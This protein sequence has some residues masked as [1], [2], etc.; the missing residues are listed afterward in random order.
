ML[1]ETPNISKAS[2]LDNEIIYINQSGKISR[3]ADLFI[4]YK[5]INNPL[6]IKY[7]SNMLAYVQRSLT[8]MENKYTAINTILEFQVTYGNKEFRFRRG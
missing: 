3:W 6:A 1:C 7:I 5:L 2:A 8:A 4:R